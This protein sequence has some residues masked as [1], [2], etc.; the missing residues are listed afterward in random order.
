M[1]FRSLLLPL[2]CF[3]LRSQYKLLW[4]NSAKSFRTFSAM[5]FYWISHDSYH[6]WNLKMKIVS[7]DLIQISFRKWGNGKKTYE[8]RPL[9]WIK[10]VLPT[11]IL[12]IDYTRTSRKTSLKKSQNLMFETTK[13]DYNQTIYCFLFR[14]RYLPKFWLSWLK[15]VSFEFTIYHFNFFLSAAILVNIRNMNSNLLANVASIRRSSRAISSVT[16]EYTSWNREKSI[17]VHIVI[18]R[19]IIQ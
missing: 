5:H 19:P 3:L 12:S 9:T 10:G 13:V 16:C 7:N 2:R 1:L 8:Y 14:I 4:K 11:F 15:Q 6:C 18:I 17:N